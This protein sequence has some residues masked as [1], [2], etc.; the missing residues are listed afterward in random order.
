MKIE[1]LNVII[2][3][4]GPGAEFPYYNNAATNIRIVG[5]EIS[6]LVNLIKEIYY[7]IDP[8]TFRIH[9]VGHSLGAHTCGNAGSN[10]EIRFDRITGLDPANQFFENT[11]ELVRLDPGDAK[12]VDAIH[13]SMGTILTGSFG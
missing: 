2:V 7:G 6:L 3:A 11:N 5:K 1:N 8:H 4:W 12:Y 9:C 10:S 13:T